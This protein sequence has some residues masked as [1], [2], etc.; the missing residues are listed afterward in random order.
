MDF[1]LVPNRLTAERGVSGYL[2]HLTQGAAGRADV[3]DLTMAVRE[4]LSSLVL[5]GTVSDGEV[6]RLRHFTTRKSY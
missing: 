4:V 6:Y 3:T 1:K 5:R 2:S